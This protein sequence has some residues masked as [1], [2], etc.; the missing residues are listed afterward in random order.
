[1]GWLAKQ[2]FLLTQHSR[3]RELAMDEEPPHRQVRVWG[4]G[5]PD[6]GLPISGLPLLETF[7]VFQSVPAQAI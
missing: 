4:W 1:M 7:V 3:V 2:S 6:Q 5:S